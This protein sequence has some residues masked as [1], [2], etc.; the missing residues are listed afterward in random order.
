MIYYTL[1]QIMFQIHNSADKMN[2]DKMLLSYIKMIT[3]AKTRN[4]FGITPIATL[5]S[6]YRSNL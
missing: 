1:K 3:V 5:F 2:G 4:K 6:P